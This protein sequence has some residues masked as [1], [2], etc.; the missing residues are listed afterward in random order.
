MG[1]IVEGLGFS[2][3]DNSFENSVVGIIMNQLHVITTS[4]ILV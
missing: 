2:F 1:H 3:I 4:I